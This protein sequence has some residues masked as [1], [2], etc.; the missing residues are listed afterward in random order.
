MGK[1]IKITEGQLKKIVGGLISEQS[2]TT[3]VNTTTGTQNPNVSPL[4]GKTVKLYKDMNNQVQENMAMILKIRNVYQEKGKIK[5]SVYTKINESNMYL[6]HDCGK[7]G[8]M[9]NNSSFWKMDKA[10]FCTS[11]QDKIREMY[12]SN[13]GNEPTPTADFQE[14]DQQNADFQETDTQSLAENTLKD[15]FKRLIK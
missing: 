12:C 1:K 8:F 6:E 5:I 11:F 15:V 10:V 2:T 9:L 7:D 3:T 13:D 4:R 14:M